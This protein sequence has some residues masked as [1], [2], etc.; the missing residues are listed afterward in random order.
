[1]TS[2]RQLRAVLLAIGGLLTIASLQLSA[3]HLDLR[4]WCIEPT[5]KPKCCEAVS[6]STIFGHGMF[7][8]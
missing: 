4:I 6:D 2:V 5:P 3:H 1:M 8:C 7:T